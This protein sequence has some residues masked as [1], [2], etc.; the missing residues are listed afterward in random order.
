MLFFFN[1]SLGNMLLMDLYF[2]FLNCLWIGDNGFFIEIFIKDEFCLVIFFMIFS[3]FKFIFEVIFL[4]DFDIVLMFWELSWV[5]GIEDGLGVFFGF[6][7]RDNI[8][9]L[10]V[11]FIFGIL[12]L[13]KYFFL[14]VCF[15]LLKRIL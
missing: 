10:L 7:K 2:V 14:L 5:V 15:L 4:L 9:V 6:F 8:E 1:G 13:L 11:W 3:F 12:F